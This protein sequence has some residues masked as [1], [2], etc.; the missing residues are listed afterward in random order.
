MRTSGPGRVG[1][2]VIAPWGTRRVGIPALAALALGSIATACSGGEPAIGS[3]PGSDLS[4]QHVEVLAVWQ[5]AEAAAFEAVLS[6]FE[7]TT[8]ADVTFTST[9][10]EDTTAVLDRRLAGDDPPDVAFLPQPG[11][12]RR[13]ARTGAILPIDGIVGDQVDADWAPV[14]QRLGRV[15]GTLY[16]LWFKAADKSLVWY[17]LAHFEQAGLVPPDDLDGLRR[18]IDAFAAAG[19]PAFSV[20]GAPSEAWTLTDWFENLYLRL[21][22]PERYDDL[23]EHRIPWTDPSVGETLREMASLLRPDAT[24][25]VAGDDTTF[26][27]SVAGVFST[28]PQAAMVMEG[29]FVPGVVADATDA[30][31]GVDV[32]VFD[33]P[34]RSAND[35]F[36]VGAGDA[37]VLMKDSTAADALLRYLASPD[38]ASVWAALGG[39]VSPNDEVDLAVYPD[40]TS[41]RIARS[42]LEA[43]DG[44]RF[45]LSDLQPVEFGG[46]TARGMWAELSRFVADPSDVGATMSRLE[47][48]AAQAWGNG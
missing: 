29:D 11:L 9:G 7:Q 18:V 33:F 32:D 40:A 34:G 36:V 43:G 5:D 13:Y 2:N 26:P 42:L 22:G 46:T 19:V 45:D 37:A 30:E 21:A 17:S 10:G 1:P 4:G 28:R 27:E 41:R 6:R 12:L 35:R 3:S 47:A 16:G 25:R 14:W 44:F 20:T 24:T 38:A 15:D 8:G 39:F 48:D 23:A 31:V